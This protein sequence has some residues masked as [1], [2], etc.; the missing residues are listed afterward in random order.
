MNPNLRRRAL[1]LALFPLVAF[2][3]TPAAAPAAAPEQAAPA[4]AAKDDRIPEAVALP[5]QKVDPQLFN[6]ALQDFFIRDTKTSARKLF[7]FVSWTSSTDENHA[8]AQYFLARSF[9]DLGL[10]HA[11]GYY[12]AR[13]ARERSNPAV[14]P[15]ALEE[16]RTLVDR[17]HNEVM[18]DQQIFGT[19]DLGFLPESVAGFAHYQQG[20]LSLRVGNERWAQTHFSKLAE[21]SPEASQARFALAVTRLREHQDNK[22]PPDSILAEFEQLADDEKLNLDARNEARLAVA[23]LRYERKEFAKA[24]EWYGKVKLPELDPGRASLY[25]EEAWTRYHLGQLRAAMG[26]LTALDSPGFR[27]EFLPD[28]YLLRSMVFR[29]LCHYLPA[30]R[31]AKELTRRF[32][33]SL[34]AIRERQDLT[35]DL[36]LRRAA[37]SHGSTRKAARYLE[38]LK[39]EA[40]RIGAY[41]G[42]FEAPLVS[43]LSRLYALEIAEATRLYELRVKE[44]VRV[45]ADKLLRGAEQVRLMDYEVGLKLYERIKQ[46]SRLVALEADEPVG[47]AQVAFKFEGEYWN[48]ELRSYRYAIQS[49]CI[50]EGAR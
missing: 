23:R 18:I 2:G 43:H 10:W 14:L 28:K 19:L 9:A 34:E 42:V 48:D 8:W 36:R 39:L 21:G 12:L 50:E 27:D 4:A 29:D 31:A 11:S 6:R 38:Q 16:L 25:L 47:P 46:G 33:D 40:E 44:S 41:A 22:L 7:Q 35:A 20:M 1:C 32:A 37:E 24:L 17:P 3:Q 30:K 26:I 45:E 15:R 13:V 49:R 5:P